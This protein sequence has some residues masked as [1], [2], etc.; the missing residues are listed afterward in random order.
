MSAATVLPLGAAAAPA[1]AAAPAL[2]PGAGTAGPAAI[3]ASGIWRSYGNTNPITPGSGTWRCQSPRPVDADAQVNGRVCVIRSPNG[4]SAVRAAVIVR[5]DGSG[6]YTATAALGLYTSS[7]LIGSWACSSAEV[8]AHSWSVCFGQ[9]RTV[10]GR[11]YA[12]GT[13]NAV[14]L[15]RSPWV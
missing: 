10:R 3:A 13:V 9:A 6:S 11:A 2:D 5:N 4:T 12:R 15:G 14:D 7:A 8:A 1:G